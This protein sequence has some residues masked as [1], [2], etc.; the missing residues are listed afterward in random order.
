MSKQTEQQGT[1][2]TDPAPDAQPQ[3]QDTDTT[4]APPPEQPDA[5][6]TSADDAQAQA[7]ASAERVDYTTETDDNGTVKGYQGQ[8]AAD[9]VKAAQDGDDDDVDVPTLLGSTATAATYRDPQPP[10]GHPADPTS[11]TSV[12]AAADDAT[13]TA[14]A[15]ATRL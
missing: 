15:D 1:P 2:P 14:K 4:P 8:D 11:R 10:G 7:E 6:K 9:L 3:G 12:G 5:D 13:A